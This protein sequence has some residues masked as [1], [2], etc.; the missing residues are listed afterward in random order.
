VPD[1]TTGRGTVILWMLVLQ[2]ILVLA[3]L[4]VSGASSILG[5]RSL[6]DE[7]PIVRRLYAVMGNI[8]A[9]PQLILLFAMLD[10][11]LYNVYEIRLIPLWV[12]ALI[13]MV[14]A[15]IGLGIFFTQA[16]R[17]SRRLRNAIIQERK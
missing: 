3:G 7:N 17:Q 10:I 12:F 5:Q 14:L 9:L 8:V 1:N 11:F 15:S 6:P 2:A 16:I 13:V 4:G